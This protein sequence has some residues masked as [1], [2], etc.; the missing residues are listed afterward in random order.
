VDVVVVGASLAGLSAAHLLVEAGVNTVV[1]EADERPGG[2]LRTDRTDGYRLDRTGRPMLASSREVRQFPGLD[3]VVLRPFAPGAMVYDDGVLH[4]LGEPASTAGRTMGAR[5]AARALVR[6]AG[7]RRPAA[8]GNTVER[9]RITTALAR[10]AATP[11]KK[12]LARYEH[13]AAQ[14]LTARGLSHGTVGGFLRPLLAALLSDPELA[15]SS[16]HADLALAAFARGQLCLPAGGAATLPQALVDALPDG[17]VHTGVR[18]TSVSTT[19]VTTA[20]HGEISC[21]SVL[22]A[23]GARSA[24]EL[25]PGLRV[26]PTHPVTVLHHCADA[27]PSTGRALLLAADGRGPVAH[28][29]VT[30]EIDPSR[31]PSG[32]TLVTSTVLGTPGAGLDK[33]VRVDLGRLYGVS[34]SGWELLAVHHDPDASDAMPPPHDH[35]RPVRLLSG[36][37]VCGEHRDT[38]TVQGALHSGRRAAKALLADFATLLDGTPKPPGQESEPL[39]AV[40]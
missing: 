32:R 2:R 15:T 19:R 31:A 23:T 21:A 26:P 35:R 40:A 1:L 16:R 11:D 30:S 28:T 36:L 22:L 34:T 18:V 33:A 5:T 17:T 20:E 38:S 12:L 39:R 6:G 24:A 4:H 37:Y 7:S 29:A 14:A 10:L 8:F 3:G 13:S 9:A 25:L 27:P